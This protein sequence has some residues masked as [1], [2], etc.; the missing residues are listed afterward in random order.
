MA[1]MTHKS[2]EISSFGAGCSLMRD[3]DFLLV[4]WMF[5]LRPRDK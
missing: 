5:L 2:E 3:D 4:A 1:K